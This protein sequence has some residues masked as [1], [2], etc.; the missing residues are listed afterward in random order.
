MNV[1]RLLI[2]AGAIIYVR[3]F[4]THYARDIVTIGLF[5]L[6][7]VDILLMQFLLGFQ[8]SPFLY[9]AWISFL[10]S[11]AERIH[12]DA[13]APKITFAHLGVLAGTAEE[14]EKLAAAPS[15]HPSGRNQPAIDVAKRLREVEEYLEL[16]AFR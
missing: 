5:V 14:Y 9:G 13:G 3:R 7:G 15:N 12:L 16:R 1:L 2:A 10:T 4:P 11:E 6:T 8:T